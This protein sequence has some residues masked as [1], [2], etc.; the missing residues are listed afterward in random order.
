MPYQKFEN[1]AQYCKISLELSNLAL[2]EILTLGSTEKQTE[3]EL[4]QG[5][6]FS[7]Y[8][9]SLQYMFTSEICK[10]LEP[11]NPNSDRNIS[12]IENAAD[13][14]LTE[15]GDSFSETYFIVKRAITELR[16]SPTFKEIKILRNQKFSH[17]DGSLNI[18]PLQLDVFFPD[19]IENSFV[20]LNSIYSV[21]N[22]ILEHKNISLKSDVPH[23]DKRTST[24]IKYH[25]V[26]KDFYFQNQQLAFQQGFTL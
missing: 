26:Y 20:M 18:D 21:M 12:S 17:S 10:L 16:E 11:S 8:F 25:A 15:L 3:I 19:L 1:S 4:L 23:W 13:I 9:L 2:S 14:L 7:R 5:P 6:P 24:F 22:K